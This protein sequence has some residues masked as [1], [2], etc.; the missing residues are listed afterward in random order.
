MPFIIL[1][2]LIFIHELGHF[3]TAVYFKIE[4]DKIYIYPFGGISKFNILLNENLLKELIIL[5]MGPLAQLIFYYIII[6]IDYFYNYKELITVYNFTILCFNLLPIYPL[7]GGK[8][9]NIILSF[10]ISFKRSLNISL[11]ISY[12]TI[13]ILS[14]YFIIKYFSINLIV[15][16][17][18]LLYK[19]RL[20]EKNKK[21]LVD[22]FL[23]ERYLYK[24]KFKKRK[25]VKN[26]DGFMRNMNH[27]VNIDGKYHTENEILYKKFNNKY[28]LLKNYYDIIWLLSGY[29]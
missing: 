18:F 2:S 29:Q 9:L 6:N 20:E 17:S 23:L 22:K 13:A 21:Y 8:L 12:I 27:L 26:L 25:K 16:I 5:I 15:I 7:D 14:G 3:L 10:K 28:W 4:I 24:Y 11:F 19:V 1:F